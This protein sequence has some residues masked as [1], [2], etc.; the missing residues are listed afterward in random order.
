M[1]IG[2]IGLGE[3]GSRYS[4]GLALQGLTVKGYDLK[5]GEADFQEKEE[6]CKNAGVLLSEGTGAL[7]D[8]CD[9]ILAVTTCSQ[10]IE[11]AEGAAPFLKKGQIYIDFNSAI[12]S[13]KRSIQRIIEKTGADFCDACSVNSPLRYGLKNH[14]VISGIHA[15]EIAEM[16]NSYQ[17][18]IQV[19]G[20]EVGQASAFKV[21]RSIYM[22]GTEALLLECLCASRRLGI[23]EQ[24]FSSIVD[25]MNGDI[26]GFLS[27]LVRT[28]VV[29]AKRRAE[30]IGAVSDMLSEMNMDNT[31]SSATTKK[32]I[33]S[34]NLRLKEKF[35]SSI[36]SNMNEVIDA[37]LGSVNI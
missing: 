8:G 3:V 13:V 17:M 7:I 30:E 31:M 26:A 24:T 36:P 1:I 29:H 34:E 22:K 4:S 10:A 6:R 18:N 28:D 33:W 5:F 25:S 9:L 16:L 2:F 35:N 19:L 14:V 23:M 20:T 21:I 15:K 37:I 32:L 27:L 11:T 12:P